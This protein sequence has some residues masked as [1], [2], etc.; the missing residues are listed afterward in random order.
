MANCNPPYCMGTGSWCGCNCNCCPPDP[1]YTKWTYVYLCGTPS[2]EWGYG[3]GG[4]DCPSPPLSF[5]APTLGIEFPEFT[6]NEQEFIFNIDNI[7]EYGIDS[8]MVSAMMTGCSIPCREVTIEVTTSG[9]CLYKTGSS[10][11]AF[12]AVGAGTVSASITGGSSVCRG[13]FTVT[14]NG[15]ANSA[16]VSDCEVVTI[17]ISP[18]S[19][20][21]C[22]CCKSESRGTRLTGPPYAFR[23]KKT[24]NKIMLNANTLRKNLIKRML[25]GN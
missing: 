25:R 24:G 4:C 10:D 11:T 19:S 5:I 20:T 21:C 15:H 7:D 1:C 23:Q 3:T 12:K 2:S 6:I 13:S 17:S 8:D 22:S 18:P 16:T 9:C 14:I